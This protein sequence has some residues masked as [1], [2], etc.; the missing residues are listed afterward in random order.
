MYDVLNS[1][2]LTQKIAVDLIISISE[3]L[4][5]EDHNLDNNFLHIAFGSQNLLKPTRDQIASDTN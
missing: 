2:T 5:I 3:I 4:A 1:M